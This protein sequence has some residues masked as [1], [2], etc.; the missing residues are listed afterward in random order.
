MPSQNEEEP[1]KHSFFLY[2]CLWTGLLLLLSA[3]FL[4]IFIKMRQ[5]K[6]DNFIQTSAD[7]FGE[8]SLSRLRFVLSE[9][10]N[11]KNDLPYFLTIFGNNQTQL[12]DAV[13]DISQLFDSSS[14]DCKIFLDAKTN[15]QML[16]NSVKECH[17]RSASIPYKIYDLNKITA[18]TATVL[19]RFCDGINSVYK[20]VFYIATFTTN[21]P[22]HS[23]EHQVNAYV[24]QK[25]KNFFRD[26][27]VDKSVKIINRLSKHVAVIESVQ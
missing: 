6:I 17:D 15:Q 14:S 24:Y 20:N 2:I 11:S 18:E 12:Y 3:I 13:D 7:K 1:E 19:H 10:L 25:L 27:E 16:V 22:F 26:V 8:D 9:V 5:D 23:G 21:T 4:P